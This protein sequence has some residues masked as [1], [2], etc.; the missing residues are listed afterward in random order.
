MDAVNAAGARPAT[1]F[2][3]RIV[4][5]PSGERRRASPCGLLGDVGC[6]VLSGGKHLT[7]AE[8]GWWSAAIGP[9]WNQ[10]PISRPFGYGFGRRGAENSWCL[11][12][13]AAS[14]LT[15]TD[16]RVGRCESALEQIKKMPSLSAS[17][18][19]RTPGRLGGGLPKVKRSPCS[20][21]VSRGCT[22]LLAVVRRCSEDRAP[23]YGNGPRKVA[24]VGRRQTALHPVSFATRPSLLE[25]RDNALWS[26]P[27]VHHPFGE[28][29]DLVR[30]GQSGRAQRPAFRQR[31]LRKARHLLDLSSRSQRPTRSS[32]NQAEA[33]RDG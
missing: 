17:G 1:F 14:A 25:H 6:F 31:P 7:T 18:V 28:Q 23:A 24:A 8:G 27:A 2:V 26:A 20:P 33:A 13:R 4:A 21:T 15:I 11:R 29:G 19:A 22:R 32:G 9:S 5:W 12:H 16:E 3:V 30:L 10:S